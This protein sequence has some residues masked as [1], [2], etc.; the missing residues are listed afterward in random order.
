MTEKFELASQAWLDELF[1]LMREVT[2]RHPDIRFSVCEVFTG[3]PARLEPD[4]DGQIAWHGFLEHGYAKLQRGEVPAEDVDVKTIGDWEALLPA[5]RAK[6]EM[7]PEGI[8]RYRALS[9]GAAAEGRI[10]RHGDP[11][12]APA[13]LM[14]IH[15]ALAERT[16]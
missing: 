5:A 1:R 7:T 11:S 3:V 4:S 10:E 12:K 8:A 9:A 15:N 2:A 13:E 16:A 14:E 6:V